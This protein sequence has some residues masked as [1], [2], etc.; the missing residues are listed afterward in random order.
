MLILSELGSRRWV[1]S[2]LLALT[3]LGLLA[4][5]QESWLIWGLAAVAL[6]IAGVGLWSD[7][8]W[9]VTVPTIFM[10][11]IFAFDVSAGYGSAVFGSLIVFVVG[12]L[13]TFWLV[14]SQ[15]LDNG[16]VAYAGGIGL[17]EL[18]LVVR[19]WPIN[20]PSRSLVLT[21][22]AFLLAEYLDRRVHG[23]NGGTLLATLGIVLVAVATI[24]L[25]ANW[26][27]V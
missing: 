2:V 27:I 14:Q 16:V 25:T 5:N 7:S 6:G 24:V 20:T 9:L 8:R 26:Q 21:A 10:A 23:T 17:L 12:F 22:G 13:C 19:F 15:T 11:S 4:L 18:F 3:S 1:G